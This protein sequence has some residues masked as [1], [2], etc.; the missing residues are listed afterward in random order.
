MSVCRVVDA[1]SGSRRRG[2]MASAASA[3]PVGL[4]EQRDSIDAGR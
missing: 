1:E 2:L 3:M 4:P